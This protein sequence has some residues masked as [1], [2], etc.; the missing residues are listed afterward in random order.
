M[1]GFL[2]WVDRLSLQ[3]PSP[4]IE[5]RDKEV[6]DRG[7]SL[8]LKRDDLISSSISGNKW[9]KLIPNL[10]EAERRGKRTILTFGGAYSNHVRAVARAGN[11]SGFETIGVIR[12]EEVDPLNWSLAQA[13]AD[14]MIITYMDRATYRRKSENSVLRSLRDRWGDCYI[15]PE[16]GSNDLG[17]RGCMEIAH[18]IGGRGDLICCPCGSGGTL[19]GI[20]GGLNDGQAALGFSALR[21]GQFL[22][23]AVSDLQVSAFG[24]VK[25]SWGINTEFHFG[26]F[27]K[28]P[29]IL[30][31]FVEEFETDHGVRL[32]SVYVAKMLYGVMSLIRR[33]A[34]QSGTRIV[35]VVT[36]EPDQSSLT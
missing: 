8:S 30:L 29:P 27:A 11:L 36:G 33:E 16:G 26:G 25:G 23:D 35:A 2:R 4:T 10:R 28:R 31:D 12:G 1:T 6:S 18:E 17:V 7:V 3:I 5:L 14:G 15:I 13:Q 22:N 21:G 32:E 9:R 19:A 34:F 24:E 20:A